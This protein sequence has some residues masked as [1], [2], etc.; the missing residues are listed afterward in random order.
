MAKNKLIK[1]AMKYGRDVL[2]GKIKTCRL[3]RLAV[4]RHF[5]D[6]KTG[7]KRG[8]VFSES[9]AVHALEFF[10]FLKHSKGEW[11][12]QTI[13]LE[14]WEMFWTAVLFGWVRAKTGFRRF[15]FA[16]WEVAR[17]NGK[18]TW[19]AGIG[20]YMF[21][22]DQE[23][24]AEVY[25]VATK[26]D[27]AKIIFEESKRMVK[28]SAPL[29][30]RIT[31]HKKTM[32]IESLAASYLPLGRDSDT[33]DGLNT[34]CG[35]IDELHAH[36]SPDMWDVI[37][38][39][40]G[41]RRQPLLLAI[42]TAGTNQFGICYEQRTYLEKI[43]TG[44]IED[45]AYCGMI[46]TL[47]D[48]DDPFDEANWI[49]ANPNLGV[50]VRLDNLQELAKK[51]Q[52]TP[53]AINNFLTKRL[54]IW[55][56]AEQ[57]WL[58]MRAWMDCG[59]FFDTEELRGRECYVGIDLS[60]KIDLTA[61]AFVFPPVEHDPFWY[62][63]L[64]FYFPAD[65]VE[66]RKRET[67]VPF[68][69]WAN[70][71]WVCLTPGNVVDYGYIEDDIKKYSEIFKIKEIC[72]DP[73]NAT[74]FANSLSGF[75]SMIEVRQGAL[76]LNEPSKEFEAIVTAR[77]FR[78]GGNPVLSWNASNVVIVPDRNGNYL[79]SKGKS[80]ESIDGVA[81]I[82]NAMSRAI[83]SVNQESIYESSAIREV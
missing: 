67:R 16:Y 82:I 31:I 48:E 68:D 75:F 58:D 2:S 5:K 29:K 62:A 44:V 78:H 3:T 55:C 15:R 22:A 41:A 10:G 34:H 13:K 14:P 57:R 54:N 1:E 12:G 4:E 38:T 60:K 11:A 46:Y 37:E 49:K 26:E 17:K 73:Y 35:L 47:D 21:I 63:I 56:A 66:K 81:A 7:R 51:A 76:T 42:T 61:S 64:R 39:S 59:A 6:L 71:G 32:S 43:L 50:S 9:K 30:K 18:S 36:K 83:T 24:G 8:I 74:Q 52:E 20:L 19:L 80:I 79:P 33:Q 77:K 70:Q 65:N 69:L 40:T 53:R 72:Y 28:K 25:T 23:P 27:Q 45:D